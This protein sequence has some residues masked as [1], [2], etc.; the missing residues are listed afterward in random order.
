MPILNRTIP[1]LS[2]LIL[3]EAS[4][5]LGTFTRAAEERCVTPTAVAKQ[6]KQLESFLNTRLFERKQQG[7]ELT[8][9]GY[10]YLEQV[11]HAL[12][13]LSDAGHQQQN[14]QRPTSLQLEVGGCF[15]HFWLLPRLDDFRSSH[16]DI[17][18]NIAINNDSQI[19]EQPLSTSDISFYYAPIEAVHQN[20]YL[21][22][23]ERMLLVCSPSFLEKRPEC[24]DLN[25]LWQQPLLGLR[26][27]LEFWEDWTSWAYHAGIEYQNPANIMLMDDQI[28]IIQAALNDAG[29][30]LAWDWHVQSLLDEGQ[31]IAL[32]PPIECHNNA[33]FLAYSD[34]ANRKGS[35]TF[36]R[37]VLSQVTS[38]T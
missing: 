19:H 28:S 15:S 22:F 26:K 31:L 5:R 25:T 29:I 9:A 35:D 11:S 38:T 27:A 33:F 18:I 13:I 3:F 4:A 12:T 1:S 34:N 24:Q 6:I 14:K 32:T 23:K 8:T 30:A 17:V 10:E 36:I 21:L 2:G 37:W 20:H 7:L 16:D